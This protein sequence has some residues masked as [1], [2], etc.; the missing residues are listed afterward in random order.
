MTYMP[1]STLLVIQLIPILAF[2]SHFKSLSVSLSFANKKKIWKNSPS[3]LN[4]ERSSIAFLSS[5]QFY[6]IL[7]S[8]Y[9]VFKFLIFFFLCFFLA[10]ANLF[11]IWRICCRSLKPLDSNEYQTKK[12]IDQPWVW[13]YGLK[14]YLCFPYYHTYRY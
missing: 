14:F 6:L 4:M 1:A 7:L 3:A 8:W 11:F 13:G 9:L 12:N 10:K 2:S 5:E